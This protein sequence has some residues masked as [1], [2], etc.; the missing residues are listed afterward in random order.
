MPPAKLERC[1]RKVKAKNRRGK[2]K[3]N[4]HAVCVASAGLKFKRH[5]GKRKR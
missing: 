2:K 5:K 1:V 4:P 3:V